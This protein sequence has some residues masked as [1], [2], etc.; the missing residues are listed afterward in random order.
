MEQFRCYREDRLLNF[1]DEFFLQ[2]Y[3]NKKLPLGQDLSFEKAKC[4]LAKSSAYKG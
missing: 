2:Y 1:R 4:G 3:G